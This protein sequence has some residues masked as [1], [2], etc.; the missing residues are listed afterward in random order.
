ML[1]VCAYDSLVNFSFISLFCCSS[2]LKLKWLFAVFP[3]SSTLVYCHYSSSAS[4]PY[5]YILVKHP[6][7]PTTW[8]TLHERWV[9]TLWKKRPILN[10]LQHFSV[11]FYICLNHFVCNKIW[12]L[13]MFFFSFNLFSY[14][15]VSSSSH[16]IHDY[17]SWEF[18]SG[19]IH[20]NDPPF[21]FKTCPM[22]PLSRGAQSRK[23][24]EG[25]ERNTEQPT[26]QYSQRTPLML[27]GMRTVQ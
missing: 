10:K 21:L 27:T 25:K 8:A 13:F 24:V 14:F 2:I 26:A 11:Y 19:L 15:E 7:L 9:F 17:I 18:L 6:A 3:L 1:T 22:G 16:I 4:N 20:I 5:T 23:G 12:N